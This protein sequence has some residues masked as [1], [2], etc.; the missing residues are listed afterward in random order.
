MKIMRITSGFARGILL[1]APKSDSTRPAT[2]AARQAI[3]SSL[4]DVVDGAKVLDIFAGTGSYGLEALSRGARVAV[5]AE[6]DRRVV[7]VLKLNIDKV[8]KAIISSG[9]DFNTRV[10]QCDCLKS[11][12]L[13]RGE[14]NLIFADPPYTMLSDGQSLEKLFALFCEIANNDTICVLEAPGEFDSSHIKLPLGF[15]IEELKRLGK[16][17]VGKP[18]QIIFKLKKY[19]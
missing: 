4:G 19:E 6:K 14:Y 13:L 15:T 1:D 2:D 17:S 7:Q 5:F 11:A 16:K 3:F 8:R 9:G 18:S 12:N 10:V